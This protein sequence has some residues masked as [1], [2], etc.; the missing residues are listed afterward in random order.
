MAGSLDAC[1]ACSSSLP[2]R[3]NL[4]AKCHW[5]CRPPALMLAPGDW[6]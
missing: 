6:Q 5:T 1:L 3:S 2:Q 4:G